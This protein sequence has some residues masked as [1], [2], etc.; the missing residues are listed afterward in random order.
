MNKKKPDQIEVIGIGYGHKEDQDT[1]TKR[2]KV[3]DDIKKKVQL[4]LDLKTFDEWKDSIYAKMVKRVGSRMY[5]EMWAKDIA[6]IA[7]SHMKKIRKLIDTED[8]EIKKAIDKFLLGLR[9]NLNNSI[10]QEDA[11][12]MLKISQ[13]VVIEKNRYIVEYE[14]FVWEVDEFKGAHDGLV[15]AEIELKDEKET[16]PIPSFIGEEVTG[17]VA[18]YNS[19]LAGI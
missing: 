5:W 15:I 1:G 6:E 9:K 19:T 14:G 2:E 17:N 13:G 8:P 7:T 18:Y 11:I 12:E 4:T 10:T 3:K 16:F